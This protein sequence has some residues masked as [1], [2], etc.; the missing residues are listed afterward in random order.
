MAD[1]PGP[2]FIVGCGRSGT[3][4]L[5][6]MLNNHPDIAIPLES[7]FIIDYLLVADR[8]DLET[9]KP[10]M[11][12]EPELV[13]WGINIQP[14][15]F[16][17]CDSVVE[18]IYL[19]HERYANQHGKTYWGQKTPRFVRH[20]DLLSTSFHKPRFIHIVRDPRAVVNS[21]IR[22]N[23][24]RSDAYHA[25]K[26]WNLD[27]GLALEFERTH[28]DSILRIKYE[29]LVSEPE[30]SI[31][32]I[33]AFLEMEF[34][35]SVFNLPGERHKEYSAFYQDIHANLASQPSTEF[36][37]KW[38]TELSRRDVLV[39]ESIN[40]DLMLALD[41]SVTEV[42]YEIPAVNLARIRLR[43]IAN[44]LLQTWR[45]IAYRPQ[46]LRYLIWRKWKLGLLREFIW[47]INY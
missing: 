11:A 40:S 24:H 1:R 27:V 30:N 3:S 41:Y 12:G 14:D 26:R 10:L 4:L 37:H 21:L 46:Y 36:I 8:F 2:F 39:V 38:N 32:Q 15:D 47:G 6:S 18:M 16:R 23:V 28:P 13:E 17:S 42:I 25:A 9:L 29:G 45:Y 20:M 19:V 22:S 43:R 33:L 7:L 5:R 34:D 44:I 35:P 31:R